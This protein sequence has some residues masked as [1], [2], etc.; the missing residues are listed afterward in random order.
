M[1]R[2]EDVRGRI[3]V[4]EIEDGALHLSYPE[5]L[6]RCW[7]GVPKMLLGKF[8]V[9]SSKTILKTGGHARK[10]ADGW[11]FNCKQYISPV[12]VFC[13]VLLHTINLRTRR[14]WEKKHYG[15]I[16]ASSVWVCWNC[17]GVCISSGGLNK[18]S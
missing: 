7:F 15:S 12:F 17:K 14:G 10:F 6:F 1:G 9:I 4:M 5:R 8:I 2:K 18:W 11:G 3:L 16:S 13:V